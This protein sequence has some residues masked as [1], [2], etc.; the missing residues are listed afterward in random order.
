RRPAGPAPSVLRSVDRAHEQL[1]LLQM[2]LQMAESP[3]A[4]RYR[5]V[6]FGPAATAAFAFPKAAEPPRLGRH[7]TSLAALVGPP[8]SR[9]AERSWR[10][11]VRGEP[12]FAER[13]LQ[14]RPDGPDRWRKDR[15]RVA[16]RGTI[17]GLLASPLSA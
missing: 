8:S 9:Q 16:R 13:Y 14:W 5:V 4:A 6:H 11:P 7:W 3:R 1:Q 12:V 2:A 15:G 17:A 10:L